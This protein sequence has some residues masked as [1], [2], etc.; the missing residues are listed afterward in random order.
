MA[1]VSNN[2]WTRVGVEPAAR[3]RWLLRYGNLDLES[4]YAEQMT[5]VLQ[6]VRAFV[7]L[8]GLDPALRGRMSS[9]PPPIEGT[10]NALTEGEA[11]QAQLWLKKGLGYLSQGEKWSFVPRVKY[12]LDVYKGLFWVH[13]R[14]N[15]QLEQFKALA[16]DSFRDGRFQFRLCPE[17]GRPFV[18]VRRQTYC[19]ARCSQAVR[20]RKWRRSN[21][22]KNREIRRQ[23][24]RKSV[25]VKLRLS[26]R[27]AIE[28]AT[29]R[30]RS[31]K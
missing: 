10:P 19:T 8:Q 18:P 15:S 14:A 25:R 16:Y 3:L 31:P 5:T 11:R 26:R 9:W 6:E 20:T 23:Q 12:E 24:Y 2:V 27:A 30:R 17:C 1:K 13:M 29:P 4:L 21:P 28:I 7:I 22:E